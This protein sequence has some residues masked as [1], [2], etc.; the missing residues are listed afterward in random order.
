MSVESSSP[1]MGR[2]IALVGGLGALVNSLIFVV[3]QNVGGMRIPYPM[4]PINSLGGAGFGG[5]IY[6]ALLRYTKQPRGIFVGLS[7]VFL[8]LFGLLPFRL[9]SNPPP[10]A[11]PFNMTTV[12]ALE[13]M[14]LV[15]GALA[16]L[17]YIRVEKR[18]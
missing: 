10:G 4:V 6:L 5:L 12:V 11:E 7:A 16:I 2:S 14:H 13:V 1:G 8:V 9:M 3:G 17:L 18:P 15:S